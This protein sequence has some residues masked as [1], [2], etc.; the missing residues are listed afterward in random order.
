M[1]KKKKKKKKS[2]KIPKG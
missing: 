2:W 1:Y